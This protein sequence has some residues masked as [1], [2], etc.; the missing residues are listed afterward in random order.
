MNL[1]GYGFTT[2]D[3]DQGM[4]FTADEV[5]DACV[6]ELNLSRRLCVD[7]VLYAMEMANY[8]SDEIDMSCK[9]SGK[10]FSYFVNRPVGNKSPNEFDNLENRLV[11]W[12]LQNRSKQAKKIWKLLKDYKFTQHEERYKK[13]IIDLLKSDSKIVD[14]CILRLKHQ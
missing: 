3:F 10:F 11:L 2:S 5:S 4:K 13:M 7:R 9:I 14:H 1:L 12:I 6:A 8:I